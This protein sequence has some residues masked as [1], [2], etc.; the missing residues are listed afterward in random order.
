MDLNLDLNN[1]L[2]NNLYND[3]FDNLFMLNLFVFDLM[4]QHIHM[5][6]YLFMCVYIFYN[7]IY[8]VFGLALHD[9]LLMMDVMEVGSLFFIRFINFI[10]QFFFNDYNLILLS[11]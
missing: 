2:L 4:E 1:L 5:I 3:M 11:I 10:F 8:N 7:N 6:S 9:L